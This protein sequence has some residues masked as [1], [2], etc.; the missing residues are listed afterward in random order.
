V[1]QAG[2]AS[3]LW[4]GF[5]SRVVSFVTTSFLVIAGGRVASMERRVLAMAIVAGCCDISGSVLFIWAA[6]AGRLD[7]AVVLAALYPAVKALLAR[8]FLKEHFSRSK[9]VGMLAALAAVPLVAG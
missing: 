3:P 1:K 7:T 8:L 4:I 5:C 2:D 9:T 6:Q